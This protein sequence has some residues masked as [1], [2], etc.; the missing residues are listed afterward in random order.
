VS[1]AKGT[2]R[3]EG[4]GEGS[5]IANAGTAPGAPKFWARWKRDYARWT[6]DFD[7]GEKPEIPD[8]GK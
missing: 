7:A 1:N 3:I 6:V 2:V 4:N 5:E 8:Q